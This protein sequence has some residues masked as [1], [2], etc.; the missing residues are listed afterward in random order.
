MTLRW[1][2]KKLS[3]RRGGGAKRTIE[4]SFASVLRFRLNAQKYSREQP[5]DP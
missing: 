4:G 1:V 2:S 3:G 5:D